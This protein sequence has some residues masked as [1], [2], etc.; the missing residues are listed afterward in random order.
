MHKGVTRERIGF[1]LQELFRLLLEHP[2]GLPA[3]YALQYVAER[4][5]LTEYEAGWY[6]TGGRRFDTILSFATVNVVKAGWMTKS[7]GFWAITDVGR[8]ALKT[9]LKPD[10]F[11]REATRLYRERRRS[12][13]V[14][15]EQEKPADERLEFAMAAEPLHAVFNAT[16]PRVARDTSKLLREADEVFVPVHY[17][18]NREATGEVDPNKFYGAERSKKLHYGRLVVSIPKR[19][20]MG[21]VERPTVW[22]LWRETPEKHIVLRAVHELDEGDFFHSLAAE[23]ERLDERKAFVFIHGFNVSFASAAHRA[24]QMAYDLFLVGE[25]GKRPCF[26]SFPFCS[27]GHLRGSFFP[28]RMMLTVPMLAWIF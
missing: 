2:N 1:L 17:A 19:H 13:A 11:Y 27:V 23:V 7:R 22:R 16:K 6:G 21:L 26:P 9:Y 3:R 28:M 8:L 20:K 12:S 25:R 5:Q 4:I 18:T 10:E 24:A 15:I 14:G